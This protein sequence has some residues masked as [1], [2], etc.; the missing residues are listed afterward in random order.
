VSGHLPGRRVRRRLLVG[1]LLVLVAG[2]LAVAARPD[3]PGPGERVQQ[4]ESQ[5]RCPVC[6]GLSVADSPSSTARTIAA[7]VARRV[8]SG[9]TDERIRQAYVARYGRG[10]LLA[11][12]GG[13]GVLAVG[14]P[15]ALA[16]GAACGLV[17][18]LARGRRAR[19]RA[20][21]A[22]D[23]ELVRRLRATAAREGRA[24]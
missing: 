13:P 23:E 8:A 11:P 17:V 14:L 6:Q 3:P 15:V 18:A 24:G 1:M 20:A 9:Q 5:L 12:T 4:L 7:D 19:G 10:I 21:D 2:S 16:L 22:R